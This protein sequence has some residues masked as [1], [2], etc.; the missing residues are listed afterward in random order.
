[1]KIA[2]ASATPLEFAALRSAIAVLFLFA[3]VVALRKSLRPPVVVYTALI[4]IA[5]VG[6]FTLFSVLALGYGGVGRSSILAYTFPVWVT[7]LAWPLLKE[8]PRGLQ[9]VALPLAVLG[10]ACI[11]FPFNVTTGL[12]GAG[13]A[14]CAG[15]FWAIGAVLTKVVARRH[16]FDTL[17]MTAWQCF[18]GAFVL[19]VGAGA[20]SHPP[21]RWDATFAFA[22]FFT[23]VISYGLG[24]F[25]W[26]YA[27][28]GLPAG[29]ASF[30]ILLSPLVGA[31]TA[32][33]QLGERDPVPQVVGF[34]VLF[35]ALVVF[36]LEGVRR[37]KPIM[38]LAK[39]KS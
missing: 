28:R 5:Q 26:M 4:G 8:R 24:W 32:A 23:S 2:L 35:V 31:V 36:S 15:I 7:L 30:G 11:L 33:V 12:I 14:V 13:Y 37:T 25:L 17:S 3:A 19:S 39:T 9:I 16:A 27:L 6:G 18:F 38:H 21:V 20:A 1:M 10:I 34:G 22:L 29:V